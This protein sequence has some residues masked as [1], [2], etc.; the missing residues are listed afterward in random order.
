[1][2]ERGVPLEVACRK[3]PE[4][5][6]DSTPLLTRGSSASALSLQVAERSLFLWN[7]EYIVSLVAQQRQAILPLVVGSLERNVNHWNPAVMGLTMN[8][9]KML[10]E[11]DEALVEQCRRR[12]E[13]QA[14]QSS[15]VQAD[16]Q[17]KWKHLEDSAASKGKGKGK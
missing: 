2:P 1:M 15:R 16:R 14:A 8:V 12:H 5:F 3:D 11:M 13:Q 10:I 7:N 9:R 6:L 4:S 17:K